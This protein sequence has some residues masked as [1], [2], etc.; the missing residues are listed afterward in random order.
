METNRSNFIPALF[1]TVPRVFPFRRGVRIA[2]RTAHIFTSG[3]LLGGY[4]FNEPAAVLEPWLW[5][6]VISG[7]LLFATDLF[8]TL[9]ILFE[10]HAI[11][12]VVKII[13]L[14]L[15]FVVWDYRVSLLIITLVVGTITSHMPGRFRHKL[16]FFRSRFAEY[17]RRV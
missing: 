10:L 8:A 11:A 2:L 4:I 14:A 12:V 15:A 5:A 17:Q 13:L 7:L 9:V 16:V 3:V 1:P 6:A